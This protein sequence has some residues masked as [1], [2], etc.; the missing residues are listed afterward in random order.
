MTLPVKLY[1]P[2]HPRNEEPD[3]AKRKTLTARTQAELE[4]LT[5]LGWKP[6]EEAK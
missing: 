5:R 1:H 4:G 3:P 2:D 6:I